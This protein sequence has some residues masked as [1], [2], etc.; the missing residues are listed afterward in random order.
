[1]ITVYE[2]ELGT[3][4]SCHPSICFLHM[5]DTCQ[6]H[7]MQAGTNAYRLTIVKA[8]KLSFS[9]FIYPIEKEHRKF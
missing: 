5:H 2:F 7:N 6:M 8:R 1:M 9:T 4:F 3:D